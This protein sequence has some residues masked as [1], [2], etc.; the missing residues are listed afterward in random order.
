MQTT[1]D[2]ERE[3]DLELRLRAYERLADQPYWPGAMT[4]LDYCLALALTV[5]LVIGFYIWGV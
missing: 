1:M 3:Q 5:A 4:A 2:R